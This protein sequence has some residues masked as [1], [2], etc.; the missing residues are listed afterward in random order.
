MKG[1][2]TSLLE[3]NGWGLLFLL[4]IASFALTFADNEFVTTD[5]VYNLYI[6]QLAEEKYS[7]YDSYLADFED[8]LE[9][10][11]LDENEGEID[12][13][14]I[15][16]DC[17]FIILQF[18]VSILLVSLILYGGI[19]LTYQQEEFSFRQVCKPVILG[20]FIFLI[21]TLLTIL[22]FTLITTDFTFQEVK[23]FKPLSL[24]SLFDPEETPYWQYTF[25]KII[26]VFEF[27]Y[28]FLVSWGI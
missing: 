10:I 18:I 21:P 22:N 27:L 17:L 6:D 12:W 13:E 14:D 2:L 5:E 3:S 28:V 20:S 4:F 24:A 26:N 16:Y 15:F 8:D 11:D 25:I 7:D 1:L 23:A 19:D 9:A